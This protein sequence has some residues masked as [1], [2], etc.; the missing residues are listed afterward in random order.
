MRRASSG[1]RWI[2][3]QSGRRGAPG[4]GRGRG[5][6]VGGWATAR[7]CR[8]GEPSPSMRG[9][10]RH[11]AGAG[12]TGGHRPGWPMATR[13]GREGR[14]GQARRGDRRPEDIGCPC[15][16]SVL[17]AES[18]QSPHVL[19][20]QTWPV[21]RVRTRAVVRV[22]TRAA[23]RV[24]TRAMR[25]WR[26]HGAGAGWTCGHRPGWPMATRSGRGGR[27]GQIRRGDRRPEDIG[28]PCAPSALPAESA[29]S[30]HVLRVRT[31]AVVRVRTRAVVRVRTRAAVRVRT[32]ART[33][34]RRGGGRRHRS[35][36]RAGP[37]RRPDAPDRRCRGTPSTRPASSRGDRRRAPPLRR[38]RA[39]RVRR[40]AAG[41]AGFQVDS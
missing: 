30:P 14:V 26:R 40:A 28:C 7:A 32:R 35:A 22:R 12:W 34:A 17:P 27:V 20:V 29:Q 10:R 13:S 19:R 6:A 16:P 3:R 25:G 33:R 37:G 15:A 2:R 9:W 23:V 11:G 24:R 41:G 21:V 5:R 31:R 8:L 18:A 1:R 39:G 36:R 38:W 4:R